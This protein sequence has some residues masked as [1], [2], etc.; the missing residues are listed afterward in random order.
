M[1]RYT[2]NVIEDS[3]GRGVECTTCHTVYFIERPANR[4]RLCCRSKKAVQFRASLPH[5][6]LDVDEWLGVGTRVWK[7][8]C[9]CSEQVSFNKAQSKWYRAPREAL[10]R[11]HAVQG[12]WKRVDSPDVGRAFLDYPIAF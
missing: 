8:L 7:L 4:E 10:K 1:E 6:N 5:Q 11:G 12:E 9:I 2:G 3:I